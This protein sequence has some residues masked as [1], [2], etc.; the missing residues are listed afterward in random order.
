MTH[1]KV[2]I[3][4]EIIETARQLVEMSDASAIRIS[5][6]LAYEYPE[7]VNYRAEYINQIADNLKKDRGTIRSYLVTGL[8]WPPSLRE[9]YDFLGNQYSHYRRL[10]ED[11]NPMLEL[12]E[13]A[14]KYE[15]TVSRLIS[16]KSAKTPWTER[17]GKWMK[18]FRSMLSGLNR[19]QIL[20]LL[21]EIEEIRKE[22]DDE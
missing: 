10:V 18:S 1:S 6:Y 9:N 2:Q 20:E 16:E 15:W 8:A 17:M 19:T 7:F 21:E 14:N 22:L 13:V 11:G 12:A 3:P 5:D 4:D